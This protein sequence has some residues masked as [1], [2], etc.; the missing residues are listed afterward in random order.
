MFTSCYMI[1]TYITFGHF[2]PKQY[3]HHSNIRIRQWI[4]EMRYPK[5]LVD[6]YENEGIFNVNN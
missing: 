6:I 4:K 5:S 1:N 2:I 3:V